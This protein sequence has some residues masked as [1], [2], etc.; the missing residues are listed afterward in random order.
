[1]GTDE[2]PVQ[3]HT[4]E[5]RWFNNTKGYGFIEGPGAEGCDI[6][7]HYKEIQVEGFKT[8]AE[9]QPVEYAVVYGPKGYAALNVVPLKPV[10][11]ASD[12]GSEVSISSA[13]Q[14]PPET[15]R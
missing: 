3:R 5:V 10:S 15:A 1:M 14:T 9:R 12:N 7:V 13:G 8:L 2:T 6:F 4:G 11:S